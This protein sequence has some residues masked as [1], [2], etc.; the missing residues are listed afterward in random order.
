[1]KKNLYMMVIMIC[2]LVF[3]AS[4]VCA[5]TDQDESPAQSENVSESPASDYKNFNTGQR[6]GTWALNYFVFPGLG[7]FVIMH[8]GLGG[9]IQLVLGGVGTG[10]SI[11]SAVLV[12]RYVF[13]YLFKD[14]WGDEGS[15]KNALYPYIGLMVVSG[16]VSLGNTIFNIVRSVTYDRPHPKIGSLADPA[17]WSVAVLPGA[18]G[19]ERI[20]L[21]YTLRL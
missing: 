18:N 3:T 12:Y 2:M 7:S 4:V 5:Q 9:A 8:D 6:I 13:G 10:L 11:A 19:V 1:M 17:A 21:A 14:Q 15:F 16:L 20:H